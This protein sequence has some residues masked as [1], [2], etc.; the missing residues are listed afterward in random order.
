MIY[1]YLSAIHTRSL[2]LV[3]TVGILTFGVVYRGHQ[4]QTRL[5]RSPGPERSRSILRRHLRNQ[6]TGRTH[7]SRTHTVAIAE[8]GE[9]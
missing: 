6:R 3:F 2:P 7:G 1:F 9:R 5:T 4:H 8:L